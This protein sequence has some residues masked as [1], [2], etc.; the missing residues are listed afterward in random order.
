MHLRNSWTRSMSS[1]YIRYVP[2][3]VFGLGLN[4]GI[5][6]RHLVVERDVGDQVLDH[7]EGLH[8]RD[9][10]RRRRVEACSSGSCTS[11]AACRSP[12]RCTSR[13]CPPCSSSAPPG[14]RPASPGCGGSRRARPCPPRQGTSYSRSCPADAS[15]RQ[16]R[17]VDLTRGHAVT[18]PRAE[19]LQLVGHLGRS[20][21]R[22]RP[23][24]LR[25]CARHHVHLAERAGPARDSRRGCGRRGSPCARAPRASPP[26]RRQHASA[27][28]SAR[29][30][31]G[32][33]LPVP[34][35]PDPR[36]PAPGARSMLLQR[37]LQ[38]VPRCG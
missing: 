35:H 11:A 26:R 25:A 13:T 34:L 16:T 14:R 19:L 38:L 28:S 20:A 36:Q 1:C 3:G 32:I 9:G 21:L 10:D 12:R 23:E 27:R 18:S 22:T 4:A 2:S 7:R 30:Q 17:I 31:P 15:P 24:P 6:L 37:L 5:S 8:R 33:E 29:C